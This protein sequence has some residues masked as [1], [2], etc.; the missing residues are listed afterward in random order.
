MFS[1]YMD[2]SV[3]AADTGC[4]LEDLP[5]VMDKRD[6]LRESKETTCYQSDLMLYIYIY[7]LYI[8]IYIYTYTY[9]VMPP[10]RISQTLSC[11]P[12]LSSIASG[13]SSSLHPVSA[14]TCC[15]KVL[16]G[17]PAFAR[18]CEGAHRSMSLIC[19]Y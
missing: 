1:L 11:H 8:Y 16:A 13:R 18:P 17:H 12:F 10:E 19:I 6:G 5:G 9:H 4:S 2:V 3:L 15:M 7:I 14:Q